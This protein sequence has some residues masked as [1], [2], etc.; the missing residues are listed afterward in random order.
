MS[1]KLLNLLL[2]VF[3]FTLYYLVIS[4]LYSGIGAIWQPEKS[5]AALKTLNAQYDQTLSQAEGLLKQAD[6]LRKEYNALDASSKEKMLRMVPESVDPIR[7]LS[8]VDRIAAESGIGLASVSY[9]D[10]PQATK[11]AGA[12]Q[13]SMS[14][15]TSY[16]KFK[17][18]MR[19]Y[20]NSLR[21]FT[22]QSVNFSAPEKE[23]D[24]ITFQVRLLTY[25]LK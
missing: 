18:F 17:E 22:L 3:S 25:Y 5:I 20:E 8:E 12:Y 4:P 10:I 13:L 9:A 1:P 2:I 19:N 24:L 14:V 6:Q 23:G 15:K 7:L 21:L 11:F 16:P